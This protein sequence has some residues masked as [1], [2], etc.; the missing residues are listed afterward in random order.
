MPVYKDKKR[1]TYF[2]SIYYKDLEG[3][4][5]K[6]TKRGFKKKKDAKNWEAEYQRSNSYNM[7][8]TFKDFYAIYRR[9]YKPKVIGSTWCTKENIVQTHIM[10][11]F[12]DKKMNSID[13]PMVLEWQSIIA[14]KTT[15][16]GK[17][18]SPVYLKTIHNQLSA[19]LNYAVNKY[20]LN[21]N[22]AR[23]AGAMGREILK[24]DDY[25]TLDEYLQFAEY[26]L[27]YDID[28][29]VFEVLYWCGLR[30]NEALCLIKNDIDFNNNIIYVNK[31]WT[32]DSEG[33]KVVGSTKSGKPRKVSMP[34]RLSNE[35]QNYLSRMYG[36]KDNDYIFP[37]YK[38]TL[39]NH[40]RAIIKKSGVKYIKIHGLRHSHISLLIN[41]GF[42]PLAIGE[43]VGHSA[44][45][46]TY[47]YSHLFDTKQQA[48]VD[49]LNTCDKE[50]HHVTQKP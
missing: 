42:T 15:K 2:V 43:R 28:Y 3:K 33:N 14:N 18:Y 22:A 35:L 27:D 31:T 46:I 24:S 48:I 25:W 50:S 40:W 21:Y 13:A 47:Q 26:A 6:K 11:Y 23:K 44:E 39:D 32:V 29:H 8:M 17:L 49:A 38:S 37:I 5:H 16:T 19:I 41:M 7:E 30:V 34:D 45:K 10:P 20:D 9:T 4:E 36:L 12:G 1:G